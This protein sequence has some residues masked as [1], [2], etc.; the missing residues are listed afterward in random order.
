MTLIAMVVSNIMAV[1]IISFI[2]IRL[3]TIDFNHKALLLIGL[4]EYSTCN[5]STLHT[6]YG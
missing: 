5:I 1:I 4:S 3:K 2:F 6:I